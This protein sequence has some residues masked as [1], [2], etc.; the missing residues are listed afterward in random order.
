MHFQMLTLLTELSV[1]ATSTNDLNLK[2]VKC[3]DKH[4]TKIA[5]WFYSAI[6]SNDDWQSN[7]STYWQQSSNS[8]S[9]TA[10]AG[11]TYSV[12]FINNKLDKNCGQARAL[13]FR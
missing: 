4:G 3:T 2:M 5:Y 9:Q 1:T 7:L 12:S 10:V 13:L 8:S 6:S 11:G